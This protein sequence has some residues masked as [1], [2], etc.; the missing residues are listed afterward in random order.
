[1][2][3]VTRERAAA[4]FAIAAVCGVAAVL[5]AQS[6]SPSRLALSTLKLR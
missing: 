3:S 6:P 5:A 1:M 2:G 4:W